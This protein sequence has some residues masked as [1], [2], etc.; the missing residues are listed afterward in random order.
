M[1]EALAEPNV[2]VLGA[3]PTSDVL[4]PSQ[5]SLREDAGAYEAEK[6]GYCCFSM[7]PKI[8][9]WNVCG[10][11]EI[12]KHIRI[13][14]LLREWRANIICLQETKLKLV[15][16]KILRSV[17]SCPYVDWVYL[18]LN[19]ALGGIRVMWDRRVV[20]QME[21]FVGYYTVACSFKMVEDNFLWAFVGGD[22]NIIRF[23]SER[24]GDSNLC[25]TMIDFSDC[26]FDLNLVDLPLAGGPFTWFNSQTW[27][28]F[29]R[30][31]IV[32]HLLLHCE[33]VRF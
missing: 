29:D 3:I 24:S 30:F 2:E 23:R 21:E 18:A 7:K 16:R 22:F 28:R 33:V 17:W 32:D 10:L 9:S 15:T 25:P 13:K 19:G 1:E 20:E 5:T 31:L 14:N 11:N 4:G 8:V 6:E 26:I 12:N 27:S